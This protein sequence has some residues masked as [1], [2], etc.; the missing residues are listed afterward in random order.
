MPTLPGPMENNGSRTRKL[1]V[2]VE[3]PA[4]A[5]DDNRATAGAVGLLVGTQRF[6]ISEV[7]HA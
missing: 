5:G 2:T 1:R 7:S 6:F 4:T 3:L